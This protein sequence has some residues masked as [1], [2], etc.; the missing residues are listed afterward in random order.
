M[1]LAGAAHWPLQAQSAEVELLWSDD[2]GVYA[3]LGL[4]L[5]RDTATLPVTLRRR[6]LAG[7]AG[8]GASAAVPGLVVALGG[9]AVREALQR[10]AASATWRPVPLLA[11]LLPQSAYPAL[12]PDWPRN[13][14]AVW[15]DQPVERFLEVL[16]QAMP[17]RRRVGVLLGPTSKALAPAL[18]RAAAQRGLQLVQAEVATADELYPALQRVLQG[19]EVFLALPDPLLFNAAALQNILIAAYR[20]RVPLMSYAAAHVR[21]GATLALHTPIELVSLQVA[22][23]IGDWALGRGL[24]PPALAQ[25]FAVAINAQVARSLALDLPSTGELE[26][27]VRRQELRS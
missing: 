8:Q 25:G 5:A 9:Q 20:Q 11:A 13:A 15:L 21:A 2:G 10:A 24:P 4:A 16:R 23:A 22:Q 18:G 6:M 1:A 14:S 19:A 12:A 3:E 27:A 7:P 17:R 26:A